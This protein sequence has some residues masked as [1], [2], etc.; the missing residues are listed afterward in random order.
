MK[1]AYAIAYV[2]DV[3]KTTTFYKNAF[4]FETKFISPEKDYAELISGDTTLAF[5]SLELGN[6]NIPIGLNPLN[7][8]EIPFAIEWAFTSENIDL[9]FTK[10]LDNGAI[11][12]SPIKTK[13]WG[14]QVGYLRDLNGHLIEICTP[15]KE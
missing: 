3:A 7:Q 1:F 2:E 11:L 4:G 6:Q 10:A 12:I 5:A 15:M 9:D 8:K 14:Q 13:P